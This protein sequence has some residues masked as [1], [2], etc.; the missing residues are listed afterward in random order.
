M[1]CDVCKKRKATTYYKQIING[2]VTESHLCS[3]C[4]KEQG[5]SNI[6]SD[7]SKEFDNLFGSFNSIFRNP[8]RI[9]AP[10]ERCSI[11]GSTISD[12]AKSGRLGCSECYKTFGNKIM[13]TIKRIHGNTTHCGKVPGA[14]GK[15]IRLKT[16]LEIL[17]DKLN[18]AVS[19]QEFEE[20]AKIRD[21]IRALEKEAGNNE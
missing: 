19:K 3:E 7:F 15:Q 16:N 6:F 5:Y 1:L 9:S 13:P 8:Y 4:A 11:C 18:E 14:K 12:I 17:R 2:Q 21:E 20:A 10:E